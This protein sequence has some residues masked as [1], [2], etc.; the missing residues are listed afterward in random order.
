MNKH[1][2]SIVD[3]HYLNKDFKQFVLTK[4]KGY[5]FIPGQ[6]VYV[7]INTQGQ[8]NDIR[9]FTFTGLNN[10]DTLELII[11][12][13]SGYDGLTNKLDKL[14]VG[15]ELLITD[16]WG[17]FSYKGDGVFIAA[18]SGIT[19]FIAILRDLKE[20]NQISGD[21]LIYSNQMKDDVIMEN[22]LSY[23]LGPNLHFVFTRQNVIGFRENRIDEIYLK[24]TI[25]NFNQ[26]FYVC[27]PAEFVQ[28]IISMLSNLGIEPQTII[29]EKKG[30]GIK[31]PDV[32]PK[33]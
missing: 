1:V 7:S 16:A 33:T 3:S 2:V 20:K 28:N 21:T 30:T 29:F 10:W 8:Q 31:L 32:K 12:I 11:K 13:H 17:T 23:L 14:P 19:P 9:P 22:E 26:H 6:S 27:G 4:P 18:G 24:E 5:K 15:S 25:K